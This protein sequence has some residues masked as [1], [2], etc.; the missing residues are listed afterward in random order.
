MKNKTT[1][2]LGIVNG[3]QYDNVQDFKQAVEN[4][5]EPKVEIALQP[6]VRPTLYRTDEDYIIPHVTEFHFEKLSDQRA[7]VTKKLEQRM[8]Y[9]TQ[10]F[11]NGNI[12]PKTLQCLI[13][14]TKQGIVDIQQHLDVL[15]GY[16]E[17]LTPRGV[18]VSRLVEEK[19]ATEDILGFYVA[20][21]DNF[22]DYLKEV[23]LQKER[24]V[25]D[26]HDVV[27][28]IITKIKDL[29]AAQIDQLVRALQNR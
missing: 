7:D 21:L 2:F 29:D 1:S 12:S 4:M 3:V 8:A 26:K 28:S 27:D 16:M 18:N 23:V 6:I 19:D 20:M 14:K 25:E 5:Y 9:F 24:I 15:T 13:D 17:F 22:E 10:E 11:S